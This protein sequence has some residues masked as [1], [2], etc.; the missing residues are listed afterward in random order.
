[1]H[2]VTVVEDITKLCAMEM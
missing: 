2:C 1:M